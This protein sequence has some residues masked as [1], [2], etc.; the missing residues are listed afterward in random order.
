MKSTVKDGSVANVN[1]MKIEWNLSTSKVKS[2]RE[3]NR[4]RKGDEKDAHDTKLKNG[5]THQLR[6]NLTRLHVL[7]LVTERVV[8]LL[9]EGRVGGDL[10][11]GVGRRSG[12]GRLPSNLGTVRSVRGSPGV[13]V[14][15]VRAE[16]SGL[17][18]GGTDPEGKKFWKGRRLVGQYGNGRKL[19][20]NST[21]DE[22]TMKIAK[23]VA[24]AI[25]LAQG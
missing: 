9:V 20:R 24:I 7:V 3:A 21:A 19:G 18:L 15:V 16:T 23:T 12:R 2:E 13:V 11:V 4:G 5:N 8:V 10:N 17:E 22:P 14:S 6:N 1:P 25:A